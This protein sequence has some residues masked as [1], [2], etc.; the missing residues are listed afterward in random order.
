MCSTSEVK[1]QKI[2]VWMDKQK[3][4]TGGFSVHFMEFQWFQRTAEKCEL[5][6]SQSLCTSEFRVHY[7]TYSKGERDAWEHRVMY[8]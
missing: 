1:T 4:Q 8:G 5:H 3:L 7:C 2:Q 6:F